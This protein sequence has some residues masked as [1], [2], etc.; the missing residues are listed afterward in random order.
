[1]SGFDRSARTASVIRGRRAAAAL[2]APVAIVSVLLSGGPA[3]AAATSTTN[4]SCNGVLNQLANRGSVQENL[5]KAATTQ[6]AELIASLTAQRT[7]LQAQGTD[8]QAQIDQA[9]QQLADLEAKRVEL[10]EGLKT[11]HL[12]LDSVSAQQAST[13]GQ[14]SD[15]Q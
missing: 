6:N 5:L 8:L 10:E 12:T 15:L 13:A 7:A 14:I 9:N 4:G 11:R 3:S 1:M 2:V